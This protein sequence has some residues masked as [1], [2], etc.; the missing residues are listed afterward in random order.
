[1][2]GAAFAP[3][4]GWAHVGSGA[5]P[6]PCRL[7]RVG[8]RPPLAAARRPARRPAAAATGWYASAAAAGAGPP[9]AAA[10][11]PAASPAAPPPPT[12]T[13]SLATPPATWAAATTAG[14]AKAASP[15]VKALLLA[16][17]GGAYI[18]L[19]GLLALSV[20]GACPG[21]AAANPG[22]AKLLFGVVG[23]PAGLTLVLVTGAE[24]FTGNV[25]VVGAA[26]LAGRVG[27]G[28]L[29]RSWAVAYAGNF[30]GS[31][32]VVAL[33]AAAGTLTGPAA[34]TA[35]AVAGTKAGLA[36][37][38]AFWRGVGCNWLVCLAVWMAAGARDFGG[39]AGATLVT[40]P[41][42]VAMGFEHSVA[43]MFFIP[44]GMA[45]GAPVGLRALLLGNLLPVTLGNIVGGLVLVA[46]LAWAAHGR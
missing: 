29:A 6:P 8:G 32:A 7:V 42:F 9:P 45:L 38:P 37:W 24:L 34:A 22:L 30:L 26:A 36:F 12:A 35:V 44:M 17:A 40:V 33:V 13:A 16:V 20:G 28:R 10:A 19:G 15:T 14:A 4:G 39:K 5:P 31:L 1:M 41:A 23:L 27:W 3:P 43:N 18:A 46:G 11:P 21:L 25:A 2:D